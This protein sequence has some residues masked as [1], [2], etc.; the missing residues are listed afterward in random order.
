MKRENCAFL[1]SATDLTTFLGC[2]HASE[3]DRA[4][5]EGRLS[6]VFH[7]DPTLDLLAET[8]RAA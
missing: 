1:L 7:A 2:G 4:V 6:K 8:R 5:A 3:L